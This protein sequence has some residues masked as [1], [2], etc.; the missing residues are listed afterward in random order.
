MTPMR[1]LTLGSRGHMSV[2]KQQHSEGANLHHE[3]CLYQNT[4]K[5]LKDFYIS[6]I[7]SRDIWSCRGGT[8][9]RGSNKAHG[10]EI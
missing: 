7:A 5:P 3:E 9:C 2:K 4:E 8:I 10:E 6:F 1:N